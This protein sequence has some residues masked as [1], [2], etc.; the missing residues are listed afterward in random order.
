M[1]IPKPHEEGERLRLMSLVTE[2]SDNAIVITDGDWKIVYV[3][4]GFER[5]SG[6]S[7]EEVCGSRPIALLVPQLTTDLVRHARSHLLRGDSYKTEELITIKNGERIW[8]NL[9]INP[10]LDSNGWII[11]TVGILTDITS[12]KIHEVLQHS[13]LNAMVREVPLEEL[14]ALACREIERI[15][16]EVTM[17]VLQ[18]TDDGYLHPLAAPSLPASYAQRLEGL[19]IGEGVVASGTAAFFGQSVISRDI[20]NDPDWERLRDHVLPLGLKSCWATPIMGSN[21]RALGTLALYYKEVRGPSSFHQQL[22]DVIVPLCALALEREKA[23]AHISQL[24]FYDSLTEL[25]NRSLLNAKAEHALNMARRNRENLAVLF[26]D[27]DRFKQV[28]DSLGHPAGDELLKTVARRLRADRRRSDIVA[29]LSGDEFIVVLPQCDNVHVTDIVEQIKLTLSQPC[30]IAGTT[31]APSASIG[32]SVFPEDG[33]DMGTLIHRADMA[34]YQAKS[35]GRGRFSFFCHELNQLAQERQALENALRHALEH[36]ELELHYQ[37]QV[38]LLDGTLYGIEALARWTHPELGVISPVRF[39]PMAEECGLI[40]DLGLWA[41]REGCRQLG[42]WRRKGLHIPT[43]SIN[44]SPTNFHNL[45]LPDTIMGA[46]DKHRL[47]PQDLTLEL[48]ESILMDTNPSTMNVLQAVHELGIQLA[49]DDFGTGYSSLS[50]LRRLPIQ[51]LKLDRSF[52]MDLE[53]DAT[54]Q[55]L[56]DAVIHI[57]KSLHLKVVAEGIETEGQYKI[58][59]QQ[60][61]HVGQGYLFS[62]PLNAV[63]LEHWL[64][65]D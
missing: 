50:Y 56:S 38:N 23:R 42:I 9:T 55:A 16:P 17:S 13:M 22:I 41:I 51:E 15:A 24:A 1:H 54:S 65:A 5:M 49:M 47:R 61:Y 58:L 45:D 18:V 48:T 35:A 14:M 33:G 7:L 46:L 12:S 25:P 62:R 60:G 43:I 19:A 8:C 27:L 26:I 34:M 39:I 52:V 30:H 29:R 11:N 32:I 40:G 59:R 10:V 4:A 57:G 2:H 31:L 21:N 3:N 6:Y 28:N 64:D 63:D 36:N 44:I 20:E 53:N 37:P